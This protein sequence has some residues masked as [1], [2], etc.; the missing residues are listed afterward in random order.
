MA[1]AGVLRFSV[2][3]PEC[4]RPLTSTR[5]PSSHRLKSLRARREHR[6]RKNVLLQKEGYRYL[7]NLAHVVFVVMNL[8]YEPCLMRSIKE[9]G[10]G[11]SAAPDF[12]PES[13][14]SVG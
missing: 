12:K 11:V 2:R 8:L 4:L 6:H 3:T 9:E 10:E 14:Y 7:N 5:G 13:F 1:P